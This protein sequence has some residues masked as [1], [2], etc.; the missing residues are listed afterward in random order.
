MR[1][2]D[3]RKLKLNKDGLRKKD[4]RRIIKKYTNLKEK[5]LRK[6]YNWKLT[7]QAV[8]FFIDKSGWFEET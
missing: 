4:F 2:G 6:K 5:I 7:S 3:L 1:G 8:S